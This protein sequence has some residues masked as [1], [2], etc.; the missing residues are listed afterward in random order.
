[1]KKIYILTL[2]IL[3]FKCQ[4]HNQ[5]PPGWKIASII[6]YNSED[7]SYSNNIA[8]S[9]LSED[10]NGD[11]KIDNAFILINKR[12][13]TF[14]LFVKLGHMDSMIKLEEYKIDGSNYKINMGISV[15]KPGKYLTACGKG[16]WDCKPDELPEIEIIYSSID[17]FYYESANS[18][19][20][21]DNK[22]NKFNRIW[23]SD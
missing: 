5:F 20:Y 13:N 16:Y 11:G 9:Y 6:N 10:F 19:F 21:W 15:V 17:F 1:M 3:I 14:G 8:P 23:I 4:T 22:K 7:L 12:K 18:Y 2:I